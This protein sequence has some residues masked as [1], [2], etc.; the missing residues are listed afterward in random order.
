MNFTSTNDVDTQ[1]HEA[2]EMRALLAGLGQ[3]INNMLVV[4]ARREQSLVDL[5]ES[6]VAH[7]AERA[8]EQPRVA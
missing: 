4:L 5:R 6:L 2:A 3:L 8:A 7:L 1:L